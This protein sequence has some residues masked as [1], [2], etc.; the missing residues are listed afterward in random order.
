MPTKK[1]L[2]I[3]GDL[4]NHYKPTIKTIIWNMILER[5][6]KRNRYRRNPTQNDIPLQ[7][8]VSKQSS[9]PDFSQFALIQNGMV[10]EVIIVNQFIGDL[11]S[12]KK[13]KIVQF[14]PTSE[15]VGRGTRFVEN[16]FVFDEETITQKEVNDE[17]EN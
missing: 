7:E 3:Y 1:E 14:D 5:F 12:K 4:I 6:A 15:P 16:K 13:T 2:K 9:V 17:K 8:L 11:L 10:E